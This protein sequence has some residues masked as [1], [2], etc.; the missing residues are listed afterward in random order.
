MANATAD[1][2]LDNIETTEFN[3]TGTE[4]LG[5]TTVI[6]QTTI[7]GKTSLRTGTTLQGKT[8]INLGVEIIGKTDVL[9]M[10][11]ISSLVKS[12]KVIADI[13]ERMIQGTFEFDGTTVGGVFSGNYWKHIEFAIP[14]YNGTQQTV[15]VGFFPSSSARYRGDPQENETMRA[16]D[17]AWYLTQNYLSDAD[18]AL[19]TTAHQE[20]VTRYQLQFDFQEHWFQP[21]MVVVGGTTGHTGRITE[22]LYGVFDSIIMENPTGIFQ[23]D[24]QLLVGGVLYAYADGH[25]MDVT[26]TIDI[27]SPEEWIRRALGGD[28]WNVLYG[29]EP[30]RIA[31]TAAI[32]GDTKPE[33]DFVFRDDESIY[34]AILEPSEYLEFILFPSWRTVSGFNQPCVYWIPETDIDDPSE[35]LDLPAT[36]T[37]TDPDPYLVSIDVD[38]KG[39]TSYNKVTVRC[40]LL[41]GTWYSKTVTSAAVDAKEERVRE[42]REVATNLATTAECDTRAQ[43]VYDYYNMQTIT[44]TVVFLLRSDFR[45]LQKLTFSGYGDKLPDDTYRILRIEYDYGE[46]GT[47]NSQTCTIIR[48][49]AFLTYLSLNRSF[50]DTIKEIQAIT[51]AEIEKAGLPEIGTVSTV[52]GDGSAMYTDEQG[53]LKPGIDANP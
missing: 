41:N 16:Y 51:R 26:G 7:Q 37:I 17:F 2:Y 34:E 35:G 25:A 45:R 40:R 31:S 1:V 30:Y 15:F 38:Q 43:D 32:W 8:S 47:I 27:V 6:L 28:D 3:A 36:V 9:E 39:E 33:V 49:S 52:G 18:L 48:D 19:L 21:G 11:T 4:I 53:T 46:G 24:E 29:L 14:D 22:V 12:G 23:D 10:Y 5:K 13:S 44:W 50:T 20:D 42:Y